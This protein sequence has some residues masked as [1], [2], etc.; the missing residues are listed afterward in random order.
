MVFG[1]A[2]ELGIIEV[3]L[4]DNKT[5]NELS[6]R[7]KV[8]KK[9]LKRL[10]DYLVFKGFLLE[11]G[12]KIIID[13]ARREIFKSGFLSTFG[14]S[15]SVF[16]RWLLLPDTVQGKKDI[17]IAD[18]K[19]QIQLK[20]YMKTMQE[21]S[22]DVIEDITKDVL[23]GSDSNLNILDLGGG[24]LNYAL[25]LSESGNKVVVQD[26]PEV[27]EVMEGEVPTDSNIEMVGLDF[28]K[29]ISGCNY[30]LIFLAN[31]TH[32]Y[33]EIENEKLFL[34]LKGSL[35]KGGR[36]AILEYV[37]GCSDRSYYMDINMM[38]TENE[39]QVYSLEE[40]CSWFAKTGLKLLRVS[41]YKGKQLI[42]ADSID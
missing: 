7:L 16:K 17:A 39:G 30:D 40:Y 8:D 11:E 33:D 27:V 20:N 15:Y 1:A 34:N 41:S 29:G 22:K 4:E 35:K 9:K 28:R 2:Y 42:I 25:R 23:S 14:H 32:I 18:K 5:I 26:L 21:R 10:I 31:I 19:S 24:P 13:S 36:I 3:L 38:L 37:K 12:G 6:K